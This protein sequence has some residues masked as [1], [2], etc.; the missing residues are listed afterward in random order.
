VKGLLINMGIGA[1]AGAIGYGAGM[2]ASKVIGKYAAG[3]GSRV[4]SKLG[5]EGP[6]GS[7]TLDC[8]VVRIFGGR[9]GEL[10]ANPEGGGWMKATDFM[11]S[12]FRGGPRQS[13]GIPVTNTGT[14]LGIGVLRADVRVPFQP[15]SEAI[16][17][18]GK[19]LSGGGAEAMAKASDFAFRGNLPFFWPPWLP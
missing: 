9:S 8:L 2:V 5:M 19:L 13:F 17:F 3:L 18:S 16:G 4:F 12:F 1:A 6:E 10:S 7:N 15:A 14:R 11:K